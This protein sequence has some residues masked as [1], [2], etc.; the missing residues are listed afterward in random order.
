VL[1]FRKFV[2]HTSLI[3]LGEG[4]MD[5]DRHGWHTGKEQQIDGKRTLRVKAHHRWQQSC[6]A[7]YAE[8]YDRIF[9]KPEKAE[10]PEG[11]R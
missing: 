10:E 7:K 9:A 6:S 1:A 5:D 8:N 3:N 2:V 11:A 4:D